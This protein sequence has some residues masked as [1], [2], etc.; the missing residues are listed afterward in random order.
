MSPAGKTVAKWINAATK[1]NFFPI[2]A[3]MPAAIPP[4]IR[5]AGL[6]AGRP[7]VETRFAARQTNSARTTANYSTGH[8]KNGMA[9]PEANGYAA[10]ARRYA[11]NSAVRGG[12]AARRRAGAIRHRPAN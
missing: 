7:L 3:N 8:A 2:R 9:A 10:Q 12:E 5:M 6:A 11:T 1:V 4:D